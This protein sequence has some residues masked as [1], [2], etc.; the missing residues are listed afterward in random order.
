[1]FGMK[2]QRGKFAGVEIVLVKLATVLCTCTS[3]NPCSLVRYNDHAT[4]RLLSADA[5]WDAR[6]VCYIWVTPH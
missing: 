6:N 3:L 1:M 5:E 4:Y 2:S